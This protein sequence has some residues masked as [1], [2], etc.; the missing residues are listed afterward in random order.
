LPNLWQHQAEVCVGFLTSIFGGGETDWV[1][2]LIGLAIVLVLIVLAAWGLKLILNASGTAV[3]GRARR[4]AVIET[5]QI[6]Q[7]RQAILLRRDDTD[8]L[9]I[10]GGANDLVV[11]AGIPVDEAA[12]QPR[13]I[14]KARKDSA[15]PANRAPQQTEP[16]LATPA[17]AV[18]PVDY[19]PVPEP[20]TDTTPV[21]ANNKPRSLRHTGLLRSASRMHAPLIPSNESEDDSATADSDT[22]AAEHGDNEP[23]M[24]GEAQNADDSS[25]GGDNEEQHDN[26]ARH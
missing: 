6:D 16:A 21:S 17:P 1:T 8:H 3:R 20:Q 9:I 23:A 13:P 25:D 2:V 22:N 26:Q 10:I 14:R 12:A 18:A 4:L 19:E 11:E 7:K 24:H 15:S 5:A